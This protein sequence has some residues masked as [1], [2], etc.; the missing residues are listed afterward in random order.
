MIIVILGVCLRLLLRIS[1]EV[2]QSQDNTSACLLVVACIVARAWSLLTCPRIDIDVCFSWP[3]QFRVQDLLGSQCWTSCWIMQRSPVMQEL[4]LS[5]EDDKKFLRKM[6]CT[7]GA[8]RRYIPGATGVGILGN[9]IPPIVPIKPLE[10]Q[11]LTMLPAKPE[12]PH[13]PEIPK[14]SKPSTLP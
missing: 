14:G 5:H 12:I 4:E 6:F 8:I 10:V 13:T 2:L 9:S 1:V 3:Q 11:S 7:L